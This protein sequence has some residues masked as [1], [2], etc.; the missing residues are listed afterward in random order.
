METLIQDLRY[1][2]RSLRRSPGFV[3]V[4]VLTLAVGV[5]ANT[6]IFSAVEGVLLRPLPYQDPDRVV[7]IQE[8]RAVSGQ[9]NSVSPLNYLDWKNQSRAFD[10][11][12][13]VTFGPATITAFDAPVPVRGLR[14]S[15]TYFDVFGLRPLLGRTF[16]AGDDAPGGV[17]GGD[18]EPA[19]V[20]DAVRV[21][22]GDRRALGAR[23]R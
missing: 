16:V 9:P 17:E 20:V 12:A 5:G 3:A 23:R 7:F 18:P 14:V 11:M 6:A 19:S 22:R 13:A 15:R 8:K 10:T 4:A 2:I 21:G 1:A